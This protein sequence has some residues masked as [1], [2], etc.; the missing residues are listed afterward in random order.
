MRVGATQL[1]SFPGRGPVA[2]DGGVAGTPDPRMPQRQVREALDT[3]RVRCRAAEEAAAA[4]ALAESR[5]RAELA[6]MRQRCQHMLEAT[7]LE[8][9]ELKRELQARDRL[10]MEQRLDSLRSSASPQ[11]AANED[12][13]IPFDRIDAVLA[14]S[15]I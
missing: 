13:E 4:A 14:A 9:L 7:A 1:V 2:R 5:A 8:V 6:R 12:D 3:L 11:P 15:P 10:A